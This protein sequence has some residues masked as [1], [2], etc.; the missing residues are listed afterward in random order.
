MDEQIAVYSTD[1]YS[2]QKRMN[3]VMCDVDKQDTRHKRIHSMISLTRNSRKDKPTIVTE[4]KRS[5]VF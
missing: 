4:S 5:V 2:L 1:Y 3:C